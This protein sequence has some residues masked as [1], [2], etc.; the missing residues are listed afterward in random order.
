MLSTRLSSKFICCLT[1]VCVVLSSPINECRRTFEGDRMTL[2]VGNIIKTSCL[3]MSKKENI[4]RIFISWEFCLW[5]QF[6]GMGWIIKTSLK[7]VYAVA[8]CCN[9]QLIAIGYGNFVGCENVEP[10]LFEVKIFTF[11]THNFLLMPVSNSVDRIF[12]EFENLLFIVCFSFWSF[13][14]WGAFLILKFSKFLAFIWRWRMLQK[15]LIELWVKHVSFR[16]LI[17]VK[18]FIH[19]IKLKGGKFFKKCFHL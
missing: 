16:I 8:G 9:K 10:V 15:I 3:M 5:A 7:H 17:D 12:Y 18:N 2:C 14:R 13:N 4:C 19:S 11:F 6:P 1:A